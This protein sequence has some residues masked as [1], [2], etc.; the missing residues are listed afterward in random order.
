MQCSFGCVRATD[1]VDWTDRLVSRRSMT[2]RASMFRMHMGSRA[3]VAEITLCVRL[4]PRGA[5]DS[6]DEEACA[7]SCACS[8]DR[9]AVSMMGV[10]MHASATTAA[11][12]SEKASSVSRTRSGAARRYGSSSLLHSPCV[13]ASEAS[14][15]S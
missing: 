15:R 6:S 5:T 2:A 9:Q 14:R 8:S 7:R 10:P 1:S 3:T 12:W 11:S 4:R 13:H